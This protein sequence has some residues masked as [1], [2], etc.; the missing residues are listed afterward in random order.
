MTAIWL[1]RTVLL[2]ACASAALL[3][4]CGSST[5]ESA[6]RPTRIVAFGDGLS[7][8]GENGGHYTVNDGSVNAWTQQF[9]ASY[10]LTLTTA[11]AGGTSY[12]QG[13]ARIALTPDAAGST[14]T[15]TV[16]QQIDTFLASGS[17]ISG[18]D[19]FILSGG[20]SDVITNLAAY[21]AGTLS[22]AQ[23]LANVATAGQA[24]SAQVRRLLTAGAKYVLVSGAYDMSRSPLA[25]A[26]GQTDILSQAS[27]QFNNTLLVNIADLGSNVLYVD[28]AYYYNL[29][30]G[31][32]GT[33]SFQD[34]TTVVCTSV[35][36]GAGIGTGT[37]QI[38]SALCNTNTLISTIPSNLTYN[39]YI[40]ADNVYFTPAA[41]RLF[42]TYAYTRF[43]AR[44]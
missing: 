25:I 12:A 17:T 23:F 41:Q 42:G 3:A 39:S 4:A 44:F 9:A 32:P 30:T 40:F 2:A 1:R 37:G 15:K 27:L 14:S 13:N 34:A 19:V 16:T 29:L 18:T 28:G 7:D 26:R 10:G 6:V 35:D 5:V 11:S 36:S 43:T 31:L 22:S 33:Y 24:L 38:N 8:L 20:T 21:S